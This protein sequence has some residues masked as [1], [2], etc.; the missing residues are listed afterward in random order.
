MPPNKD[1]AERRRGSPMWPRL[2]PCLLALAACDGGTLTDPDTTDR[3]PVSAVAVTSPIG[4]L[5]SVGGTS[6]LSAAATT[7]S[8]EPATGAATWSSSDPSIAVVTTSGVVTGVAAGS[9]RI[10]ATVQSVVGSLDIT[11]VD[12]DMSG[13]QSLMADPFAGALLDALDTGSGSSLDETWAE[14]TAARA[15][16]NLTE[17]TACVARARSELD[18]AGTADGPLAALVELFTTWVDRLLNL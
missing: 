5:I 17:L 12:A 13:I 15:E 3:D 4:A 11:V 10:S 8:G 18:T 16:G 6:T 7:A 2:L 14:C 1:P 9:A